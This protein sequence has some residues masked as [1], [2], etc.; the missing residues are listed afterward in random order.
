MGQAPYTPSA[1][2]RA[3]ASV[4]STTW[5]L[6]VNFGP[7]SAA[8]SVL[9][10]GY[11]NDA[12][13]PFAVSAQRVLSVRLGGKPVIE[14]FAPGDRVRIRACN[15][16]MM[17]AM[18]SSHGGCTRAMFAMAGLIGH[19]TDR[20]RRGDPVVNGHSWNPALL[21]R[22]E[23]DDTGNGAGAAGSDRIF[24]RFG[25]TDGSNSQYTRDRRESN[26]ANRRGGHA[27]ASAL[28]DDAVRSTL[29][30]LRGGGTRGWKIQLP[31]GNYKVSVMVG[32]P[33][34]ASTSNVVIVGAETTVLSH[35]KLLA[36]GQFAVLEPSAPVQT[37]DDGLLVLRCT[38]DS[39]HKKHSVKLISAVFSS[40]DGP[41]EQLRAEHSHLSN[42]D[43][44][45]LGLPAFVLEVTDRL[46]NDY[47]VEVLLGLE[48]GPSRRRGNKKSSTRPGNVDDADAAKDLETE[49]KSAP[50]LT[51]E[52]QDAVLARSLQ[53]EL[54]RESA[55]RMAVSIATGSGQSSGQPS[56]SAISAK[57]VSGSLCSQRSRQGL[58][59]TP[60]EQQ[61]PLTVYLDET[62]AGILRSEGGVG[63][64][65]DLESGGG[66]GGG[67]SG[68][69]GGQRR[70][71]QR[72]WRWRRRQRGRGRRR[73]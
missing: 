67:E 31:P 27:P 19:V 56:S 36:V 8:T 18:Q 54:D 28:C 65:S 68:G 64:G 70:R 9:P 39:D 66:A 43:G 3:L 40:M 51:Q 53:Q 63:G 46:F 57:I 34:F 7:Q 60:D 23:A 22:V 38:H 69:G 37:T 13:M 2:A 20:S 24:C 14:N 61:S 1:P 4:S 71:Q 52:E 33:S 15:P 41:Y 29:T 17:N 49:G 30:H 6:R 55:A 35:G 42:R 32:D 26:R 5:E 45:N 62:A 25:W 59:T 50:T 48:K 73:R 11:F 21:E 58:D 44:G 72:R 10:L 12:G 16:E 47:E